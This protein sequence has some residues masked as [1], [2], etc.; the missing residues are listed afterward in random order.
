MAIEP[1]ANWNGEQML[2]KDVR[3]SVLDRAFLFGDAIYEVIRIYDGRP[4]LF[5]EH[6]QRLHRNLEK[7]AL[8]SDAA[9]IGER[10]WSLLEAS[11][12]SNG[13]IYIQVTRGEAPRTH[14]FPHPEVKPNELVYVK[15]YEDP[16]SRQRETGASVMLIDDLRWKRCDIKSVNLLANCIGAEEAYQHGCD[17]AIFV[18]EHGTLLEG[19]HTSL[20]A[21]Q[22][23]AILTAPLGPYLLPGITR[24]LVMELAALCEVPVIDR[25][26]HRRELHEV[27]EL[28]LTGTSAEVLPVVKVDSTVIG[29]GV[30]GPIVK[31]LYEAYHA[32]VRSRS[33]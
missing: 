26:I 17:E 8:N 31:R 20:F 18:D 4:F 6:V 10:A 27:N 3:V 29:N 25:A 1:L 7:M 13:L 16:Y 21:V 12:I 24:S 32:R 30:P 33:E 22:N 14:H 19:T 9:T 2:L 23:G 11:Q 5:A 28:F 15:E